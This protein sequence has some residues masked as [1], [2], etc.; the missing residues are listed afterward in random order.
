MEMA[1]RP[2]AGALTAVAM[3]GTDDYAKQ[4]QLADDRLDANCRP[5][6]RL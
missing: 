2:F 5:E 3:F 4:S 6:R 1:G